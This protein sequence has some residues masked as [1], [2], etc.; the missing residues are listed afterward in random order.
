MNLSLTSKYVKGFAF[1]SSLRL[2]NNLFI[3]FVGI[4]KCNNDK[5]N[6]ILV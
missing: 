3:Y 6:D 2:K 5:I 1:G 4:I